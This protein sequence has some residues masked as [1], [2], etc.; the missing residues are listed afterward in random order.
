MNK[1]TLFSFVTRALVVYA[2]FRLFPR[3]PPR[4]VTVRIE[5]PPPE[6]IGHASAE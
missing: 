4:P 1:N 3:L 6:Y 2:I 5:P